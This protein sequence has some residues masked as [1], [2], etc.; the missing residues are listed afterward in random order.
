ML[1]FI[2]F[3]ARC[4]FISSYLKCSML[5]NGCP[6]KNQAFTLPSPSNLIPPVSPSPIMQDRECYGQAALD[7]VIC[8]FR[9]SSSSAFLSSPS[10]S[11]L[12]LAS[13]SSLFQSQGRQ[14]SM[15]V[16]SSHYKIT[17]VQLSPAIVLFLPRNQWYRC[18]DWGE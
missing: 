18:L 14:F 11:T 2:F 5:F 6:M 8:L 10:I 15:S 17:L 9:L 1:L 12:I 3:S 16:A 7:A 4:Q 13:I